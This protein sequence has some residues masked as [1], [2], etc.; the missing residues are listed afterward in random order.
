MNTTIGTSHR[1]ESWAS[2][3]SEL[4][5]NV[6]NCLEPNTFLSTLEYRKTVRKLKTEGTDS[7]E[8]Y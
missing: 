2:S 8:V 7:I 6:G 1:S 5:V 3:E 4:S